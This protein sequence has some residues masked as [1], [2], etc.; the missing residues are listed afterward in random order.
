MN[1]KNRKMSTVLMS[2]LHCGRSAK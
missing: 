1:Y 2:H